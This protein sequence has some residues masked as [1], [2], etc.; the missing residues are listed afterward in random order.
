MRTSNLQNGKNN[1]S[2]TCVTRKVSHVIHRLVFR[3]KKII[4]VKGPTYA[5]DRGRPE[6][7]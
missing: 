4:A 5:V 2:K 6:F 3:K 1:N 7:I